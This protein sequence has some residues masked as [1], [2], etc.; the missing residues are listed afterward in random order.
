MAEARGD[1]VAA[2]ASG[3]HARDEE[4]VQDGLEADAVL[5]V[6][7]PSAVVHPLPV[8]VQKKALCVMP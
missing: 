1:G 6:V 8:G 7:V 3:A 5:L 4:D 2:A